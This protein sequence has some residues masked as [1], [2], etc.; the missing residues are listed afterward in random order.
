M[1]LDTLL[2]W[3]LVLSWAGEKDRLGWWQTSV[4]DEFAGLDVLGN[5]LGLSKPVW[6]GLRALRQAA[7]AHDAVHRRAHAT[8]SQLTSLFHWGPRVDEELDD[9]FRELRRVHPDPRDALPLLARV[10]GRGEWE[11]SWQGPAPLR[12]ELGAFPTPKTRATTVGVQLTDPDP[13]HLLHQ[14]LGALQA[15]PDAPMPYAVIQL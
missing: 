14:L 8:P 2:A 3:Q 15:T 4:L 12:A 13:D 5:Q 6:S 7:G 11:D 9:R 1:D 10:V